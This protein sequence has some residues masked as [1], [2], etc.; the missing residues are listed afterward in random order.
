VFSTLD[1]E[2]IREDFPILKRKVNGRR[3]IYFDNAATTQKPR[4]VVAAI[5]KY[6]FNYNANVHRGFHTL[7]QEASQAYEEA[8][9]VI[10]KF[11]NAYSWEEIIDV[12]NTTDGLNLVAWGW[13]LNNLKPGDEVVV[14]VMD[15]HSNMLPW[16]AV[17]ERTGAR[18][19]YVGVTREG[20]LDYEELERTISER[21]KVV[22]FPMASNVVGTINNVKRIAR[23]AH[24]VGAIAVGDG[25][26]YVP[27]VPT[28]VRDLELDFIAFS[29]H[30]MLGPTG[31]GVLWGRRDVLESMKPFRV[32]GDTIKDVTLDSIV[33]HDLPWRFVAGTPNIAG[34]IGLAEAAKYLM[35]L[36]MENVREHDVALVSETLKRFKE[37]EDELAILGPKDPHSRTGL[38]AFNVKDLHYHTVGK[39]LDL[40]GIAVRT[41]G[42]CAHPLHYRL[43]FK[44]SV[45]ASYYI[46]NTLEEVEVFVEALKLIISLKERLAKEPVEEVCTGT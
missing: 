6:Y 4:Q 45:R 37:L 41:G 25:A 12:S 31:I 15:H 26:Q 38:V 24:S 18:V 32:G 22:A 14:T 40:F 28:N 9:E 13:G 23:L 29:G 21:T 2:K 35:R 36:G 42:H 43:G 7:S 27:H 16:R 1:V 11:I 46:Y 30:K 5:V 19:K 39:A 17:A 34:M 8:H 44:G 3:L 10:A 33:W 20:M